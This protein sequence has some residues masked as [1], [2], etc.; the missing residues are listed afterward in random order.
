MSD[1][2]SR[3]VDNETAKLMKRYLNKYEKVVRLVQ[4]TILQKRKQIARGVRTIA[5]YIVFNFKN[6]VNNNYK[7]RTTSISS[8]LKDVEFKRKNER[9]IENV[10]EIAFFENE[11]VSNLN[12]RSTL[13]S[14]KRI[15]ASFRK[16]LI[17]AFNTST[18]SF[19]IAR[20]ILSKFVQSVVRFFNLSSQSVS[21]ITEKQTEKVLHEKLR[22]LFA[23]K[24]I[25]SSRKTA[26]DDRFRIIEKTS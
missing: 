19:R 6:A 16:S 5:E 11:Y 12:I 14:D 2:R 20:S 4:Q 9:L 18:S 22:S 3:H 17:N 10:S 15:T 25:L 13:L 8:K 26:V 21:K 7:N 24:E 23:K 1:I